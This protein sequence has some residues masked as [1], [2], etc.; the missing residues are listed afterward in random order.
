MPSPRETLGRR[1]APMSYE[2]A[3]YYR[4]IIGILLA[5]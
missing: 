2:R 3:G 5:V 1:G 4:G